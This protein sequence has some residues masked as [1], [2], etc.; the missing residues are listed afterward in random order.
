MPENYYLGTFK[1]LEN[2]VNELVIG[3]VI[4][5]DTKFDANVKK[6][7]GM[8]V[9]L[10]SDKNKSV[11]TDNEGMAYIYTKKSGI[12][13]VF[14]IDTNATDTTGYYHWHYPDFEIKPGKNIVKHF[15]ESSGIPTKIRGKDVNGQDY[16]DFAQFVTMIKFTKLN[17][18]VYKNTV[19]TFRLDKPL[20]NEIPVYMNRDKLPQMIYFK[21]L[22]G[23]AYDSISGNAYADSLFKGAK[24]QD[25]KRVKYIETS[26]KDKALVEFIY[27][28][29]NLGL[30]RLFYNSNNDGGEL[31]KQEIRT[32]A[33][34]IS[35]FIEPIYLT[36]MAGHEIQR[37]AFDFLETSPYITNLNYRYPLYRFDQG[38][39]DSGSAKEKWTKDFV[40]DLDLNATKLLW[41]FK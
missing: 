3:P 22:D 29:F 39:K 21:D 36:T 8:K 28:G 34:P 33:P 35:S 20:D 26:D 12:D 37:G 30:T 11:F 41:W 5:L 13:T 19:P 4:D 25:T 9:Y 40:V 6:L 24:L 18:P 23:V 38:H 15:R 1:V 10:S 16:L 31:K 14:V 32:R 17:D 27:E 2:G 7:S